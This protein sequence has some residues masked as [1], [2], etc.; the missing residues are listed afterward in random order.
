MKRRSITTILF[1]ILLAGLAMAGDKMTGTRGAVPLGSPQAPQSPLVEGA[2]SRAVSCLLL[3]NYAGDLTATKAFFEANMIDI[4]FDTFDTSTGAPSLTFLEGFDCVLLMENGHTTYGPDVG[5]VIHDFVTISLGNVVYGTFIWQNWTTWGGYGWGAMEG[6]CPMYEA[7]GCE[8]TYDSLDMGTVVSHPVTDGIT[9]LFADSYRGGTATSTAGVTLGNW[10]NGTPAISID[11]TTTGGRQCAISVFP[12]Y[13]NWGSYGS[14]FGGD[15][16]LL[17]ENAIKWCAGG[18]GSQEP[19]IDVDCNGEDGPVEVFQ[20]A[21]CTITVDVQARGFLGYPV[22]VWI[23]IKAPS[24]SWWTWR[25]GNWYNDL[26]HCAW[27]SGLLD[28]SG[29]VLDIPLPLGSYKAY[30]ALETNV[31]GSLD[32]GA[33]YDMDVVDFDVVVQPTEYKWD[34]GTTDNLL[35]WTS[36]GDMVG[37]HCFDTIP[38]GE[39]LTNVGTIFG[40]VLYSNYAPGNG[41]P[42][43]FYVW[44][45]TSF[46]DPTN[47]SLLT[48][49]TGVVGNVDTDIHYWD[50]CPCTVTTPNFYVAYN[51]HHAGYE[52]CLAI[53]GSVTYVP[54]AAFYTG[55]NTLNAFDPANLYANQYPPAESPYGFWT[56]RAEY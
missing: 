35:C 11:D 37:M 34:S 25:F 56:V 33:I 46:G 48:Q 6:I 45:A 5:A 18:S 13:E 39:N 21:N 15:F 27:S 29:T 31:N 20:G 38:G 19:R 24:G 53:D 30:I 1:I 28:W 44:E 17:I 50:A 2:G 12:A 3:S 4:T 49:G 42:T 16:Y 23:A 43:D 47:A 7:G 54:G 10:T 14:N 32:L 51:L 26:G 8:Y 41:T 22:D 52:Y 40:S 36:G 55:T 9:G